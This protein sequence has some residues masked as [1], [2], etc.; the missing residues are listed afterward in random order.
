MG[1]DGSVGL[2]DTLCAGI[3]GGKVSRF[4]QDVVD[5]LIN[6]S[7]DGPDTSGS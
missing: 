2:M 6:R 4:H 7:F 5:N 3:N 1:V